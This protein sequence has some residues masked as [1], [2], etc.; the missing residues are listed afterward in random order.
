M[1]PVLMSRNAIRH[2]DALTKQPLSLEQVLG[3]PSIGA[4]TSRLECARRADG[5]AA[6]I[7]ASSRA[8]KK[9][10]RRHFFL[11]CLPNFL[12]LFFLCLF[13]QALSMNTAIYVIASPQLLLGVVKHRGPY[14]HPY[15][16]T[17]IIR[18]IPPVSQRPALLII[19]RISMS[20]ILIFL[21]CTI[22]FLFALF[23]P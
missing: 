1:V 19:P 15:L 6:I 11:M 4:V 7:V 22:V 17:S 23:A 2:P 3:A 8:F 14:I 10:F 18:C 12:F 13:V 20:T 21:A 5:G 16:L 9:P